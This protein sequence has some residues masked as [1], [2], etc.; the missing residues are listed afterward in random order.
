M[1]RRRFLAAVA[2]G[3]LLAG[4]GGRVGESSA[5]PG[6]PDPAS[7]VTEATTATDATG[8]PAD[9]SSTAA[10]PTLA[11]LG[12]PRTICSAEVIE[13]FYIRAVGRPV[14]ADDWTGYEIA[15]KYRI[16][17]RAGDPEPERTSTEPLAD[18]AVVVGLTAGSGDDGDDGGA[19][20]GGAERA[21]AYPI[22]VV[23]WHEAVNDDFG[24]PVLVTFCS[25]CN[26]GLVADRLVGGEPATFGVSG[27]LWQPPGEYTFAAVEGGRS[28]G[29]S[30]GDPD[31][32]VRNSGNLVLFDDATGSF[33][34]QVLGRAICGPQA[35][36]RF[37][38][39]PATVTRWDAWR[40]DHPETDVLL[41]PPYS[42]LL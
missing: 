32:A 18:E 22:P 40:A 26:T 29:V 17:T 37:E 2:G 27:Q 33:W 5:A 12:T 11:E 20:T 30:T 28:F 6:S 35:G 8:S 1:D 4:C 9:S 31:A 16:G 42:E 25:I 24:G 13:D 15:D 39:R 14:F 10:G 7:A 21:R 41:P 23:W 3:S 36:D 34:S 19:D 38:I